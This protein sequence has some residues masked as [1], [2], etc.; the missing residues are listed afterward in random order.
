MSFADIEARV[1]AAVFRQLV[2]ATAT[3]PTEGD[4]VVASVVFDAALGTID[5]LG[6]QTLQPSFMAT[7]DVAV[8][9]HE[10]DTITMDAPP[11]SINAASYLVRGVVPQAEGAMS[12]V[13]LARAV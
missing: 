5:D 2:N 11:L 6:V 10:G 1:T 4:P 7:A 3:I 9:M 12:R 13:I 8:L